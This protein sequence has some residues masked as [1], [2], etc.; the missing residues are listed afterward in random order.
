MAAANGSDDLFELLRY[1]ELMLK[2]V[3]RIRQQQLVRGEPF[4][5]QRIALEMENL[6]RLVEDLKNELNLN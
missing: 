3:E 2:C 4:G 1:V 6:C 5:T